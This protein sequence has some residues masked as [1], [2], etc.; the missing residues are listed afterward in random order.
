MSD[1]SVG[2]LAALNKIHVVPYLIGR[3]M[4]RRGHRMNNIR[5]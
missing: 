4:L 3:K 2:S 5:V 1:V